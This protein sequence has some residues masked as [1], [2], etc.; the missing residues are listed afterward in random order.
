[1][2][3][4]KRSIAFKNRINLRSTEREG[5]RTIEGLIP[6]DSESV[7]IWGVIE[8][9]SSTAFKKVL[10][11]KTEVRA[12]WNHNDSQ[13]LGNTRT[14]T[15]VLEDTQEGLLC[16]CELPK[17]SYAD[18]LFEI[19]SR[20]DVTTM[21]F[22]FIPIDWEEQ[23][24]GRKRILK[25]VLLDEVSFGVTFPAYPGTTS[26]AQIRS[27]KGLVKRSIDVDGINALLEKETLTDEDKEKITALI[28]TLKELIGKTADPAAGE[29]PPSER[30][31]EDAVQE[32]EEL[33]L[34]ETAI[35]LEI[36]DATELT[37]E[38]EEA[39]KAEEAE[40]AEEEEAEEEEETEEEK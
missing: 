34:L 17:T 37:P 11:D 33:E 6:Y 12:M 16:R 29:S 5:K 3:R 40:E 38:V 20:G 28:D 21:S 23:G 35:E 27:Q 15:L 32:A 18:D 10:E 30:A 19:V 2:K 8:T 7:P 25:E 31:E 22:G 14:G 24:N 26:E 13:V 1:M 9:I 36:F 39:L 4:E